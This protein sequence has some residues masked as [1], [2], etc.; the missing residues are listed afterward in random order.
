MGLFGLLVLVSVLLCL[1]GRSRL[2]GRLLLAGAVMLLTASVP[3][4]A[5]SLA[6]HLERQYPPIPV[7]ALPEVEVAVMLGGVLALPQPPRIRA[8]LVG[9]SD[10]LLH[11]FRIA[12]QG[13]AGRLFLVGGA[14]FGGDPAKG[15]AGHARRLLAEWGLPAGRVDTADTSR[16]TR[17]D[18]LAARDYLT[19]R[20]LID[21]PVMLITS[22]L[23]MP[24]A[25]AAF[26]GA[27]IRVVPAATDVRAAA[28]HSP[29]VFDWVPS[30][31]ALELTTAALHEIAGLFY[32]R[33]RGWV[34]AA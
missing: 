9:S 30:A 15:D 11:A 28:G 1:G 33:W 24:R 16:T 2:A 10:R 19:A 34:P 13:K 29:A 3:W 4:V 7:A 21:R 17:E 26:R 14:V 32:Y 5:Q 31:A 25:V 22:A 27:G 12:R 8:E 23:H 20:G 6:G 18:V